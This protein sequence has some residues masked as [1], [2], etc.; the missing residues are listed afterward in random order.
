M[1]AQR[2]SGIFTPMVVPFDARGRIH[3]SELRRYIDWLIA[4]GVHGLYPNGSTG[5]FTRLSAEQRR[6]IVEITVDQAAGR[7]PV[8]AGAAEPNVAQTIAACEAYHALG[9]RAVAIVCPFYYRQKTDNI[10]AYYKEIADHSPVDVTLYNI[11]LFASPLDA[12]T[13]IRLAEECPNVVGIKDSSGDMAQMMRMMAAIRPQRPDFSFLTGWDTMLFAM[14]ATGCDGATI[15]S[16]GFVPEITQPLYD[17][18]VRGDY[19]TA[20]SLQ[21]AL[22]P[23]FDAVIQ[24]ADFPEGVRTA[25]TVRGFQMGEGPQTVGRKDRQSLAEL[26]TRLPDLL[27]QAGIADPVASGVECHE[28]PEVVRRV[29]EEVLAVLRRM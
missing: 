29:V 27:A 8:L 14:L 11:P 9:V 12:E 5:E 19:E 13:V 1:A 23:I 28:D 18:V 2:I 15:C 10:Y 24:A 20:R 26:A 17:A 4:K 16:S 25:V 3:E 7:V 21:F 6:R 22:L